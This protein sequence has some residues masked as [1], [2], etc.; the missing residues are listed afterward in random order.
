M[1]HRVSAD[2]VANMVAVN[3]GSDVNGTYLSCKY[4]NK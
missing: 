2:M 1:V 3:M 4:L